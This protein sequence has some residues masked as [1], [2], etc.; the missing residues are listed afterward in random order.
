MCIQSVKRSKPYILIKSKCE[1]LSVSFAPEALEDRVGSEGS[2]VACVGG[3]V[4]I[5]FDVM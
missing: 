2:A 3:N 4:V 1:W 5:S